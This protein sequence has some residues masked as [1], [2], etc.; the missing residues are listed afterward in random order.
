ML[1]SS[2]TQVK[3]KK[4]VGIWLR[5]EVTE[6]VEGYET[7]YERLVS[8]RLQA[9]PLTVIVLCRQLGRLQ[10][11]LQA[12]LHIRNT[13][14]STYWRG[15]VRPHRVMIKYRTDYFETVQVNWLGSLPIS[16]ICLLVKE[17][18]RQRGERH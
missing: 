7:V 18:Y 17:L 5:K 8:V 4:G 12:M 6:A 3:H 15:P 10:I 13:V 1:V 16:L 9:T 2:D 11:A 14:L